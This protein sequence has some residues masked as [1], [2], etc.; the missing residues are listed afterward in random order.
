MEAIYRVNE[1]EF[2]GFSEAIAFAKPIDAE[3]FE[4]DTGKRRWAP[5]PK[6]NK[7]VKH[8]LLVD[9]KELPFTR[10]NLRRLA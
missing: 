2:E 8:V 3:V 9:G 5:I 1:Q 4:I 6:K 7:A 10:V